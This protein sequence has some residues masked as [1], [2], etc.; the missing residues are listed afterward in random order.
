MRPDQR[1]RVYFL[2]LHLLQLYVPSGLGCCCCHANNNIHPQRG[3]YWAAGPF[4]P[5]SISPIIWLAG[6]ESPVPRTFIPYKNPPAAPSLNLLICM[7]QYGDLCLQP[8]PGLP[9]TGPSLSRAPGVCSQRCLWPVVAIR[10]LC[11][12]VIVHSPGTP[13]FPG[14]C[15]R[16]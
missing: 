3:W 7:V 6:S 9:R 16:P 11:S 13:A 4:V 8:F 1:H 2:S 5:A 15:N 10:L 12:E 14:P